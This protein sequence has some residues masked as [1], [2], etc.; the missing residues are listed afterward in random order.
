[1]R[2]SARAILITKEGKFL[3]MKRQKKDTPTYYVTLGGG[4]EEKETSQQA[5]IRELKEE[6]GSILEKY[7]FSFHFEDKK[8]NNSADFYLCFEKDRIKPTGTEWKKYNKENQ[9]E[10][11][12]VELQELET[13]NLKPD[14]LKE[15]FI[16]VFKKGLELIK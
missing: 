5:L 16:E 2:C 13:L 4:I 11:V 12:E 7:E 14:V 15:K 3:L 1:M 9:Y 10:L 8:M 6:S